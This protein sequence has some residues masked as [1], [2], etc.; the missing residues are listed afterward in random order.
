MCQ[1]S[2]C[3]I[4]VSLLFSL[5]LRFPSEPLLL[6]LPRRSLAPHLPRCFS[7]S[8]KGGIDIWRNFWKHLLKKSPS[9]LR[10]V[11]GSL[12]PDKEELVA[13][14]DEDSG[15]CWWSLVEHFSVLCYFTGLYSSK[16][17]VAFGHPA[18]LPRA[19]RAAE[20]QFQIC[21]KH[22]RRDKDLCIYFLFYILGTK[23]LIF[24]SW[25][26][27][28]YKSDNQMPNISSRWWV[29]QETINWKEQI[30]PEKEERTARHQKM[31]RMDV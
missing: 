26:F 8:S 20:P 30:S 31:L 7:L 9:V 18:H 1:G 28:L 6:S 13:I 11:P 24:K 16:P 23:W 17:R 10:W 21:F 25:I 15:S 4:K 3:R 12:K 29:C 19:G 5:I 14:A 2:N 22:H 27:S